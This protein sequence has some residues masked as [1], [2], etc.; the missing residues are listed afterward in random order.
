[1]RVALYGRVSSEAQDVD[2]SI[3]AQLRGL[4]EYAQRNGHAVVAEFIDEAESGRTAARP[5]FREM[6]SLAKREPKQFDGIL[7]WKY[8]RFARNR[9]DSIV[10]KAMLR[11]AGVEV[12]SITEPHDNSPTGRLMEAIIESLDEFYSQ[13]LGEEVT[14]GMRESASRGFYLSGRTPYGYRKV[15][16]KDGNKERTKLEIDPAQASTVEEI[17]QAILDGKG[18]ADITRDLN[19]RGIT[20]PRGRGWSKT[21]LYEILTNELYTGVFIWGKN[22]KRGFEPI[23]ADN[24]V[25]VIIDRQIFERVQMEMKDRAP[26]RIHPKRTASRFLLS[27]LARCGYCGKALVGQDA[28]G[29]QFSYYVCGTLNKKGAGSCQ[30][31]YLNSVKFEKLIVDKVK[32]RILTPENL[33]RLV[34]MVNEEIDNAAQSYQGE[35]DMISEEFATINRRLGRLYDAIE[36][37]SISFNDLA[38]RIKELRGQQESLQRRRA[39]IEIMLAERRVQ[40]ADPELV[41][42]YV[43]DMHS[44]LNRSSLAERRAFIRSFVREIKVTGDEV[45]L[46]YAPPLPAE[47]LQTEETPVLSTIRYGGQYRI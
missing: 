20:A 28:K 38:P 3:A 1:M 8:S 31:R 34:E 27:G 15:R 26:A 19:G 40:L 44:L 14:R 5:K 47:N 43:A 25:P 30:A 46:T 22:S 23:R 42:S 36:S 41:K 35:M 33:R 39:E 18:L 45:L 32:E 16:V 6:V 10:Y 17:Y 4:R 2:L 11:K 24:A 9:E 7:V 29:G 13:N 21:G 12:I 37:G